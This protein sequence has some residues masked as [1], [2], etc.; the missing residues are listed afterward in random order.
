[1]NWYIQALKNYFNFSGRA[2]RKEFWMF[3]LFYFIFNVIATSLDM[4]IFN[5]SNAT[6][7]LIVYYFHFLQNT[8]VFE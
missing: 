8:R 1:M 3:V 4:T 5:T 6:F 7:S 2:R